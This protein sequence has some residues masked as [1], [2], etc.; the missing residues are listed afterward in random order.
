MA[1]NGQIL[2]D[3]LDLWTTYGIFAVRGSLND[4]VKLPSMKEDASYS[5]PGEDGDDIYTSDRQTAGRDVSISFLLVG[6]EVQ[7]MFDKR[8]AF[9]AALRADGYRTLGINALERSYDLLYKSCESA[10]FIKGAKHKIE[11]IL[12]F[13][14]NDD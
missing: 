14:L 12:K 10:K 7:D 4:L 1:L 2:M 6:A 3:G 13:Q 9:L 5:W 11:L 8:D